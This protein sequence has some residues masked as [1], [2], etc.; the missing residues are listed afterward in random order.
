LAEYHGTKGTV[1]IKSA[2]GEWVDLGPAVLASDP[3]ESPSEAY[4]YPAVASGTWTGT[5]K[6]KDRRAW[7]HMCRVLNVPSL[8]QPEP[9]DALRR[10]KHGGQ[11]QSYRDVRANW[12]AVKH[13]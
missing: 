7:N 12:Q 5:F 8:L 9:A 2:D 6:I 3:V 4:I 1:A 13:G 11:W 10:R